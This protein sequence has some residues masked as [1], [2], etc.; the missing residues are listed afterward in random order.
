M[1]VQEVIVRL[2]A[3]GQRVFQS[4]MKKS[5]DA[6]EGVGKASE[7]TSKQAAKSFAKWAAASGA[8]A[9]GTKVL[10]DSVSGAVELGDSIQA[11]NVV[12]KQSGTAINTWAKTSTQRIM[13]S[14]TEALKAAT[15]FG[16]QLKNSFGMS[17]SGAAD[18]SKRMV[19]LG[20]DLASLYGGRPQDAVESLG[21]AL[22]GEYDPIEKY[23]VAINDARLKQEAMTQGLYKGHGDLTEAAKRAATLGLI[24]K[25][26]KD[27]QGDAVRTQDTLANQART[28]QATY[29][30]LTATL[31]TKLVPTLTYLANNLKTVAVAV[32][33]LSA[34]W[35]YYRTVTTLATVGTLS[36]NASILLIPMAIIALV[37]GLVVLYQKWGWFHDAVN[38]T[39]NWI[40]SHWPLLVS[41]LLG[42]FGIAVVAIIKN[43]DK[44]KSAASG[45]F[46]AVKS[47]FKKVADLAKHVFTFDFVGGIGRGIADWLN[48]HTPFGDTINLGFKKIHIPALATGGTLTSSGGVLVGES[49]PEL[50]NLPRGASVTPL[51][52]LGGAMTTNLYL[53][54]RLVATAVAQ[55]DADVRARR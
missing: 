50:L 42:P 18:M 28:A 48:A 5:A 32:G 37:A 49:G 25:Q 54:R 6:V 51:P 13:M 38:N 55:R 29:A 1:A 2:R 23:G 35:V 26:T 30:N 4:D 8:V 34:A 9:A 40:K 39:W 14:R 46:N 53:D 41:I 15:T 47:A 44:I 43:F 7:S 17:A 3:V 11:A 16:S 36:L 20:A 21:S 45:V 52:A 27:A 33:A 24:W 19:T 31:G 12:F 10:K 22:R